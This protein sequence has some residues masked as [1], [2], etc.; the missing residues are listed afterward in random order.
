MSELQDFST[1]CS[2]ASE[3]YPKQ[4]S[5]L[6]K[7]EYAILKG[8]PCKIV[9]MSTSKTGKHGH[10]KVNL[11]GQCIFTNKRYEDVQPSTHNVNVPHVTRKD[12]Q[13]LDIDQDGFASLMAED[14]TL[15]E[16]LKV[17]GGN[18]GEEM[19]I[20]LTNGENLTVTVLM[21]MNKEQICGIKNTNAN[22]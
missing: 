8:H 11:V 21:A 17:P 4:C 9:D 7:N 10:A 1:G 14:S 5:A 19:K 16:D 12:Y 20:R 13:L 22:M 3:T 15:K 6:R 18:L 2:G